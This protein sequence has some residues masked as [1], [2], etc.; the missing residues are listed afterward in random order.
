MKDDGF[1]EIPASTAGGVLV[2]TFSPDGLEEWRVEPVQVGWDG[3]PRP[4]G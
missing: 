1:G 4:P 2:V 3:L